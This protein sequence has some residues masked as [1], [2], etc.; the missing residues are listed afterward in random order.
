MEEVKVL[1][2]TDVEKGFQFFLESVKRLQ[3]ALDTTFFDAFIENGENLM[4]NRQVRVIDGVPAKEEVEAIEAL[5]EQLS[6][7]SLN[8][9]DKRKITQ[10]VLLKGSMEEAVQAN[11]QLTPDGIG[12]LFVYILEQLAKKDNPLSLLDLSVGTGNLLYTV[13]SNLNLANITNKGFGVD[14]DDTLLSVAAVNK[15]W[16]DLEVELFHQDSL[17]SLLIDPVDF[18]LSDL[19][20]GYYAFDEKVADFKV[21]AK[22]EHS[23]AHHVLMEKAMKHVKED[24]FGLFLVP[25][26]LLETPQAPLLT[27]WIKEEV[28][29][30]AVLQLPESLFSQK[31]LGKSILIVQNRGGESKQVKEV[32]LAELPSLK[33]NQSVLNFI[34]EF[35]E[36][37]KSNIN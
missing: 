25:S 19:P 7:L 4:E 12:F 14:L 33:D 22:D 3:M 35:R 30:Q 23:Y 10:L 26:N 9:E 32:L 8:Q 15:E 18:T 34:N 1:T 11:H 5:Y 36:W 6:N 17:D 20:I 28:Y 29:L 2:Q 24:G 13:M 27:G 16:L 37:R 31:G 21:S